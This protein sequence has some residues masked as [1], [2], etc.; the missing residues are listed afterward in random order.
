MRATRWVV[1]V[2]GVSAV[3]LLA[4]MLV[5]RWG[6]SLAGISGLTEPKPSPDLIARGAYLALM[7]DC[8]ACHSVPGKPPFSGGLRMGIPIG[9]IYTTNITPDPTYGIGKFTLDD[10]DRALRFGV[11]EGHSLYPA[12]PYTSY[13]S[14]RAEDVQALYAYFKLGVAPAGV[15]NQANDIVFPLSMRWPLTFWRWMFAPAAIPYSRSPGAEPLQAQGAYLVDGLGHCGECHTPRSFALQLK[16]ISAHDGADYLSGAVIEGYF[17]P[18]LR[19]GAK[20]TL[21]DWSVQELAEFLR[22]GTNAKGTAFG[23]MSDVIVHSTQHLT[24]QDAIAIAQHLKTVRDADAGEFHF[25]YD[26]QTHAQLKSGK[27]AARGARIY[28]DNCASCHRP[29]GRGYER[30]FPGLAGNAIVLAPNPDSLISVLLQGAT[31][32]R[33]A[34]APAQFAMPSFAWRLSDQDAADVVTF[35]RSS[36]GNDAAAVD[37]AAVKSLRPRATKEASR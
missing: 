13:A 31:T 11:A 19:S 26:E 29:D 1:A 32:P 37:A 5:A 33:T 23:S 6:D 15:P 17:A 8:A 36:W 2:A 27:D 22:S 12:M 21:S 4:V 35:I 18:S 28:L 25:S 10:F 30:V 20:G 34:S 3:G 24:P 7:G 14:T 9:A 16:A